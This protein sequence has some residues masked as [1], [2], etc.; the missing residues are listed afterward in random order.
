LLGERGARVG[1]IA[2]GRAGLD[3]AVRD[4][5]KA[6]GK[7]L[8][9]SAD[10]ADYQQVAEAASLVE[11]LFGPIDVW[12]NDAASGPTGAQPSGMRRP[13]TV[14]AGRRSGPSSRIRSVRKR[15]VPSMSGCGPWAATASP[16]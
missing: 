2:R 13:A 14:Y 8:A 4:V 15:T 11:E 16:A 7:A 5:E 9:I 3:G 10:V 6:G 12:I 1:L